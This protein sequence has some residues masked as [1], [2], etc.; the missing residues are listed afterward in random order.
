MNV[1]KMILATLVAFLV[2]NVLTTVWYML[3]DDAN[4]VSFRKAEVNY[5]GL[6]INHLIYAGIFVFLFSSFYKE[7][8]KLSRALGY[9]VLM[10][11]LMFVPSGIVV[12]SIWTVDFN[13]IFAFNSMA[14]MLIGG[15]MGIVVSKIYNYKK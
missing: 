13:Q 8:P 10:G 3:S 2:S 15:L 14:H 5:L 12:R 11:A 1:K 9:G 6:I 7:A 4:M